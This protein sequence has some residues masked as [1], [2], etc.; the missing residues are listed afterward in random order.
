MNKTDVIKRLR[1][2]NIKWED[3]AY[4]LDMGVSA[5]RMALKRKLEIE[6]LGEKPVIK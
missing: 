2:R 1:E 5:A 4:A 6:E 3:I